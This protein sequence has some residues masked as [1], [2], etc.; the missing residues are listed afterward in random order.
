[1]SRSLKSYE[2]IRERKEVIKRR[3]KNNT[4]G[5][6]YLSALAAAKVYQIQEDAEKKAAE[7]EAQT[8]ITAD[9]SIENAGDAP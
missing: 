3:I 7:E 1:M 9:E 5:L 2:N 8:Y 6:G 4:G